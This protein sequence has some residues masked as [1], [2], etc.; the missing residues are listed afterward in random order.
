M[1][2]SLL[3]GSDHAGFA[4]KERLKRELAHGRHEAR[5]RKIETE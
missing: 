4:L 1:P 5:I 3:I 2:L